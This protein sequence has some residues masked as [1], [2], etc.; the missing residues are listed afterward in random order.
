M[1][2]L[3]LIE[4]LLRPE[5]QGPDQS[6]SIGLQCIEVWS[7]T[8]AKTAARSHLV[9]TLEGGLRLIEKVLRII[10]WLCPSAAIPVATPRVGAAI[11]S[12]A[13]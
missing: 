6:R 10:E 11:Q 12:E 7:L 5:P 8:P 3:E 1:K 13:E 2:T 9:G 4:L